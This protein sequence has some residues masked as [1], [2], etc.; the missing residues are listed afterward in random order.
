M[1]ELLVCK[2]H[3]GLAL[4]NL[5]QE[6]DVDFI[7]PSANQLAPTLYLALSTLT[8]KLSW[9]ERTHQ[10]NLAIN[11]SLKLLK[12]LNPKPPTLRGLQRSAQAIGVKYVFPSLFGLD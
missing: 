2:F 8:Q 9:L 3:R 5:L 4:S 10:A 7:G 6:K 11:A 12:S 1:S